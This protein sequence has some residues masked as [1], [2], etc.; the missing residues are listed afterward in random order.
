[1]RIWAFP[2]FYPFDA[3]GEKWKGIFAHRQYKGL[4]ENGADLKVVI[5]V[6]WKPP[7]P[8]SQ[9]ST[10]W[11][12][13]KISY[14]K[15][16]TYDG[17]DVYYPRIPNLLPYALDK[18]SHK[19]KFY[20]AVADLF[21]E[22]KVEVHPSTDIFFSQWL[23]ESVNVQYAAHRLGLK[24]AVLSI[25][26]DVVVWPYENAGAMDAFRDLM[27]N[28]DIR[29]AC[30][31]YLGKETNKLLGT[32]LPYEVV[33][34][35]VDYNFFKP[36]TAA[37]KAE[38]RRKYR[39]P[40]DK[41]LI[42]NVGTAI[43]RKGWL[44]LFDALAP[45]KG[46]TEEFAVMAV[47][48]GAPEFD[49]NKEAAK[50]GLGDAFYNIGEV[51]PEKVNEVFNAVDI[52]CLPSH[53][54]GLANANIEAM[55]SGLP[56]IT[57]DVCGHPELITSGV[58]GLLVPPKDPAKLSEALFLLLSDKEK[59]EELAR[60]GREFIVSKWGN[61]AQNATKLYAMLSER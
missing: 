10:K 19:E 8:L 43:T 40:Q 15:S 46:K 36:T 25:G 59:R 28:A 50:R 56:V 5:P 18:R 35:G 60:V 13:N 42:L 58:N 2:S 34:W 30:A 9:V 11:L 20:G 14:P 38:L 39:L 53:W 57:T 45:L 41:L 49:L 55:S 54:E 16:M 22:M 44:D 17:I 52:F 3:P 51:P 7:Y 37:L 32:Q 23:P 48:S 12:G 47:H 27:T 6:S 1:M 21:K 61:F 33:N 24:S 29:F 31:D 26:D 4:I